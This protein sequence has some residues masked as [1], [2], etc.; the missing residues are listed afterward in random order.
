MWWRIIYHIYPIYLVKSIKKNKRWTRSEYLICVTSLIDWDS[1]L[2]IYGIGI[3]SSWASFRRRV[4]FKLFNMVSEQ[5]YGQ[6]DKFYPSHI[7]LVSQLLSLF[8]SV[9][10]GEHMHTIRPHFML[11]IKILINLKK[12]KNKEIK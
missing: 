2:C 1:L 6:K 12:K 3:L 5:V 8:L 7:Y 9:Y 11:S 10:I 4:L